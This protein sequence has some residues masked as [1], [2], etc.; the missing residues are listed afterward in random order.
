MRISDVL[1]VTGTQVVTVTP[2]TRVRRLLNR[3]VVR[4]LNMASPAGTRPGRGPTGARTRAAREPV[5]DAPGL[6][7]R[8]RA[9]L[10]LL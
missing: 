6:P 4:T 9:A 1:R 8:Q 3:R 5:R 2:D 10:R 7:T